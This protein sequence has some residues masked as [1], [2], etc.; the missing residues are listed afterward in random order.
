MRSPPA[1]IW[2]VDDSPLDLESARRILANR[3][4]VRCFKHGTQVLE[5]LANEAPPAV[6]VMDWVMPDLNGIEILKFLRSPESGFDQLQVLLLTAR[7]ESGQIVQGLAAGANDYVAKPYVAEELLARVEALIRV[8]RLT[9]RL[10]RAE[11]DLRALVENAPDA[12]LEVDAQGRLTFANSE[13]CKMMER[14]L[15]SMVGTPIRTLLPSLSLHGISVGDGGSLL[16]IPDLKV[17]DRVYAPTM[18]ALPTDDSA[19]TTIALRD[20]TEQ[21]RAETR[22]LDFYSVI[23]HDLR[24]PLSALMLRTQLIQSGRRGLVSAELRSDVQKMERSLRSLIAMINDFLDLARLEGVG[25]KVAR[26]PVDLSA[27]L[28]Q[29]MDEFRPLAEAGKLKLESGAVPADALATGDAQRLSQVLANLIGNAIKFTPAGGCVSVEI[30]CREHDLE[31]RVQDT[32]S[33]IAPAAIPHLFQRYNRVLDGAHGIPGTGLG[34]M[35]VREI[36]EA[37]EGTVGVESKLKEGSTFWFRLPRTR[38]VSAQSNAVGE[39]P[40]S[41]CA[42]ELR[43]VHAKPTLGS[44][45]DFPAAHRPSLAS[46]SKS[47]AD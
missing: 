24:T 47:G 35:I 5:L 39:V 22:R 16:P 37:H 23:A 12:L 32:G 25:Y 8:Q 42:T 18:R 33:G 38:P 26:E 14:E 43:C 2:I 6:L 3:Y 15:S 19:R 36:I 11:K 31:V 1:D 27:L 21:R 20:V 29:T 17:R 7:R 30:L 46:D 41:R 40:L 10:T 44:S 13:A 34:L 45:R 28:R 9:E 4:P